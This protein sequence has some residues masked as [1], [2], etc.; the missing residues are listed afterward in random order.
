ML[1]LFTPFIN[2]FIINLS[3][4]HLP[5]ILPL[6]YLN[7]T[8]DSTNQIIK[9]ALLNEN[10]LKK[11]PLYAPIT[12]YNPILKEYCIFNVIAIDEDTNTITLA[13]TQ[14]NM[15][16]LITYI[17]NNWDISD[18]QIYPPVIIGKLTLIPVGRFNSLY[19]NVIRFL[20][21]VK[22]SYF[23]TNHKF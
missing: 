13:N 8:F 11:T 17:Q 14:E 9:L 18:I 4:L 7:I 19:S 1:S 12:F 15:A 6:S 20:H 2:R 5:S 10:D 16:K 22:I 23:F 3:N 21:A